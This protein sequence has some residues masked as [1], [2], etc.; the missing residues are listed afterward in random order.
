MFLQTRSGLLMAMS[1]LSIVTAELTTQLVTGTRRDCQLVGSFEDLAAIRKE[2]DNYRIGYHGLYADSA[3][4]ECYRLDVHAEGFQAANPEVYNHYEKVMAFAETAMPDGR[5]VSA[6][7]GEFDVTESAT[8]G[9]GQV[10]EAGSAC[11]FPCRCTFVQNYCVPYGC[12]DIY[13]CLG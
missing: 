7:T 13:K 6:K 12:H 11:L 3:L 4:G 2:G 10:C 8:P 1:L 9:C 5:S